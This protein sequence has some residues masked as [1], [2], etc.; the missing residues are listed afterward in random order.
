MGRPGKKKGMI[1][2]LLAVV[3]LLVVRRIDDLVQY[4]CL[5]W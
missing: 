2:Q 5:Q 3:F 1:T 4:E